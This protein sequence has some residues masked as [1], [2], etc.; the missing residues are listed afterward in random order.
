MAAALAA[1]ERVMLDQVGLFADGVAVRQAGE[2]TFRLCRELLDDVHHRRHRRDL[3]RRSRTS[4]RT[5]APSPSLPARWLWPGLKKYVDAREPHATGALIAINSGANMNFDRLRHIA[6]RAE[7]GEHREALLA[8]T[9]PEQPGSYR[10][11]IQLL[12]RRTITEFNYRYADAATA[13][14]LRRRASSRGDRRRSDRSSPC[15]SEHGYPVL[16]ISDNEMAKL[17]VRYMVGGRVPGL[18]DE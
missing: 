8:V 12:G 13:H 17:H 14:D 3:R 4:S 1:G 9:I 15:C 7:I 6:E 18:Q 5:R 2:E 11:F 10:R 16:D